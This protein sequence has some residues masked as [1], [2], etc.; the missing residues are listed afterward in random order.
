MDCED[1]SPASEAMVPTSARP[2]HPLTKPINADENNARRTMRLI[3]SSRGTLGL[4]N[5][6][7]RLTF[8]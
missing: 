3:L 6:D 7:V 5:E 8:P 4:A 2:P 1:S